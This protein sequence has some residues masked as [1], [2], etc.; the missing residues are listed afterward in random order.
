MVGSMKP[1]HEHNLVPSGIR[2]LGQAYRS[3][4]IT[5]PEATRYYLRRIEALN[6]RLNCFITILKDQAL[7][8]AAESEERLKAGE[9]RGPLDGIPIAVKDLIYIEGV[10]CT[11]GSR[12]LADNVATYDAAVVSRLR[13]AGAVIMGTTNL[14]E[15]AAGVTG[16]NPHYGSV[17]NPWDETREPGGS[18][19]GSGVAVSSGLSAAAIGTDTGGSVRIPGAL[20]GILGFKPSYGRV[21]RLGVIPLASSLDTVGVLTSCAWD[22]AALLNAIAGHDREDMTT[23]D[24]EVSDYVGALSPPT[25]PFRIGVMRSSFFDS[26][27]PAV[28]ENFEA[29]VT[30]LKGIGCQTEDAEVD[31]IQG[32]FEMWLPVRKVEATAFHLRWLDSTPELYGDDVRELLEEGRAVSGVEYVTAVNAR[33]S[34]M[35]R[36]SQTMRGFDFLA[37]PCTATPAPGIDRNTVNLKGKTISVRSALIKPSIPFNY[38]GCPVASV[39]SGFVGGLPVGAQLVGKLFDEAGLLKIVNAYDAKYGAYPEPPLRKSGPPTP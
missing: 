24:V 5:P 19:S 9:P 14:H 7:K 13:A 37:A 25:S 26:I 27:D 29:F 1:G 28:E 12:I 4:E 36:F 31:W 3:G 6:P 20:C 2:G 23:A 22:A 10:R 32:A 8:A 39:P 16:F 17:R 15:F 38:I 33:P 30:R 35:E 34:F 11:A 18:S 21:S